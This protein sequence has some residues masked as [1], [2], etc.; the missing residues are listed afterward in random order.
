MSFTA[1]MILLAV[2]PV[3]FMVSLVALDQFFIRNMIGALEKVEREIPVGQTL[4]RVVANQLNKIVWLERAFM[5]ADINDTQA[6]D[7]AIDQYHSLAERNNTQLDEVGRHL[8]MLLITQRESREEVEALIAQVAELDED[9]DSFHQ[10]N[11]SYIA[12]LDAGEIGAAED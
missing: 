7:T 5:A 8:R 1:R 12:L 2:M 10:L 4:S 9:Y 3:I 6:Y 11:L